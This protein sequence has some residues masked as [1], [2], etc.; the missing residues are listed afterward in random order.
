M[1]ELD[2]DMHK[3]LLQ[4]AEDSEKWKLYQQSLLRYLHFANEPKKPLEIS[5][6]SEENKSSEEN[7]ADDETNKN[8]LS[9]LVAVIPRIIQRKAV[10]LYNILGSEQSKDVISWNSTGLVNINGTPLPQSNIIDLISDAVRSRKTSQAVG[11]QEFATAL[12]QMN[13][14]MDLINN[15]HYKEFIRTQ[16]GNGATPHQNGADHSK[17]YPKTSGRRRLAAPRR[18]ETKNKTAQGTITRTP[19]GWS[20]FWSTR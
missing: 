15:T 9:Q 11:W 1:G 20:R 19:K 18:T 3:I 10:T 4:K 17:S 7:K 12:K 16:K 5:F 14:P 6:P 2:T 8:L 13:V